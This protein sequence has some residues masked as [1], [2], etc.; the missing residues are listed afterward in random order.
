M[1]IRLQ[2]IHWKHRFFLPTHRVFFGFVSSGKESGKGQ[3]GLGFCVWAERSPMK[4]RQNTK[5]QTTTQPIRSDVHISQRRVMPSL[6]AHPPWIHDTMTI[7]EKKHMDVFLQYHKKC[8][9]H[10]IHIIYLYLHE[11]IY[12]LPHQIFIPWAYFPIQLKS[13]VAFVP[14]KVFIHG[15]WS[16]EANFSLSGTGGSTFFFWVV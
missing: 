1:G 12:S 4:G 2:P 16:W 11:N 9:L 6:G 7:F 13:F 15:V 3:G 10:N 8:I 5:R 14:R